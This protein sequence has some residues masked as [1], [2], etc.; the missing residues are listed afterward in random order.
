M[1]AE[2]EIMQKFKVEVCIEWLNK[3]NKLFPNKE[4]FKIKECREELVIM[5]ESEINERIATIKQLIIT[6]LENE[7]I[8]EVRNNIH[9]IKN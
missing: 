9:R 4:S 5:N 8:D 2:K 7:V 1:L 3:Y 6:S